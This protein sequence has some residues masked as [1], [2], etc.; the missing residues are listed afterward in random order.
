MLH[1]PEKEYIED[2][3]IEDQYNRRSDLLSIF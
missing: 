3:Y 1:L 2:Q